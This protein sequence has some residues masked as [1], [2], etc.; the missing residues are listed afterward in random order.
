[1]EKLFSC[2]VTDSSINFRAYCHGDLERESFSRICRL[3]TRAGITLSYLHRGWYLSIVLL[4]AVT[5]DNQW[6]PVPVAQLKPTVVQCVYSL[7]G[8]GA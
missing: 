1:M 2:I 3:A 7:W 5:N 8:G 6:S 4:K